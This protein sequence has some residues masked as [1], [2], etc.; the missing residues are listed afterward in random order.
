[1]LGDGRFQFT[2]R[3]LSNDVYAVQATSNFTAWAT[4]AT[5]T[6]ITGQ[7]QW[8]DPNPVFFYRF[9]RVEIVR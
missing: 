7:V 3:G 2:L 4:L 6:N 9:Y 5:I 1:M 8:T